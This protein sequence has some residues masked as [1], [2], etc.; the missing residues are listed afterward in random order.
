MA[1]Q[2]QPKRT[3]VRRNADRSEPLPGIDP[4]LDLV[5]R[6][7]GVR[8]TTELD[9][10]L[11]NLLRP[12]SLTNLE[13]AI[14]IIHEAVQ[15]DVQIV[16]AGDYDAD[17]ATGSALAYLVLK[18]FGAR[19]VGFFCPS[20]FE[21]GY[22]LSAGFVEHITSFI[23]PDLIITVDNGI[24]SND[25]VELA[26]QRG[27]SVVVTDH[28]LP[29]ENLPQADAIVNPNLNGDKFPS[30][31]L[32]GVGVIFYVL[33]AVRAR[34][35]ESK[36]FENEGIAV[37]NMAEYLDLVAL[38]TVADVVPLDHN[39]RI[40]ISHG[41]KQINAGKC[42]FGIKA[43][44]ESGRRKIGRI[45]SEDLAFAAGPRLNASG[46]LEDIT[47]GIRS[48]I[49]KK[50]D[51]VLKLIGDIE[52]LNQSRRQI[53]QSM[54]EEATAEIKALENDLEQETAGMCLYKDSWHQGVTGLIA[55]QIKELT[56][57]PTIVF[58][59][60]DDEQIRGSGRSVPEVNIRDALAEISMRNPDLIIQFGGHAMAAGLTLRAEAFEK[61]KA[62]FSD[63]LLHM[64]KGNAWKNEILSD[65]EATALDLKTA[66]QIQNGGPWGQGFE[67]PV[68]DGIFEIVEYQ[69]LQGLH[70]RMRVYSKR[71]QKRFNAIYF[72][73]FS[74]FSSP[75]EL[76]QYQMVYRLE[77]NEFRQEK[78]V[79]LK[80]Q[81]MHQI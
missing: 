15:A 80:V 18:A 9:N 77:V 5:Y 44:L 33:S 45:V 8:S 59:S 67:Y 25:G 78:S 23:Q 40:L 57:R 76:S 7:R 35:K 42:R 46:R 69:V 20:R 74:Q 2:S 52:T 41:L 13:D 10:S 26:R 55:S 51:E 14:E 63:Q 37:P 27:I 47:I 62:E 60:A 49:S 43:L 61:F 70:L 58:S 73:Y 19:N 6:N 17:G 16:I 53:Q 1:D 54:M 32:A 38:G 28:H 4:I 56:G 50:E 12:D 21:Y 48:L 81:Y 66:E 75:P 71:H 22:G 72:R 34:L 65:G 64:R 36:W 29:G 24:S 30:K 79:Q 39:N 31:N 3:I 11:S 68:F